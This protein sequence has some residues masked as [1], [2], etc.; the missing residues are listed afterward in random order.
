MAT[1]GNDVDALLRTGPF[2]EALRAAIDRS[3]LTLDR[4]RERLA[5]RGI[6]VSLASLSYWRLGRSRP[7]RP[8]SLRAVVA[9]EA[10]LGLPRHS[11]EALLGPPRPRGRWVGR[12]SQG[13]RYGSLLEP[14]Q[15]LAETVEALAG[16]S[17]GKLRPWWLDEAVVVGRGGALRRV[18]ARQ[19]ARAVADGPDRHLA[20]YCGEPGEDPAGIAFTAVENC[21]LGRVRRHR[22]APV[23]A[24]EL[25]FDRT[26][27]SGQTHLFEYDVAITGGRP[28]TDYRRAF[29]YPAD[30]YVLSVRFH[31]G[32]LPVRCSGFV[33]HGE[34]TAQVSDE[35]LGMTAGRMVH[36]AER[37][38]RPGV[39]GIAW[40][41]A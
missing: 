15:S 13:R 40:E 25:L 38:V 2:H 9:I 27:R 10:I 37:E 6:H 18:R 3:G 29:R 33:Q 26:L 12:E 28:A 1:T 5:R 22:S 39:V 11:L 7:E 14:A 4:L 17:D 31:A 35:E 19:V 32:R 24:A 23:V 20:V 8:D 30:S 41:W 16:P 36:V 21:R 34:D